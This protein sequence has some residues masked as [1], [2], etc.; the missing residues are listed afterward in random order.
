[1]AGGPPGMHCA[2]TA[3]VRWLE[4]GQVHWGASLVAPLGEHLELV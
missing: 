4:V 2:D 1:M 3:S